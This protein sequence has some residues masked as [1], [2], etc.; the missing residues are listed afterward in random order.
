M[1]HPCFTDE[2]GFCIWIE[3]C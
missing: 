2:H 1:I 3:T